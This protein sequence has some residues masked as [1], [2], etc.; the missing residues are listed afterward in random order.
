[1]S[2]TAM[3]Q[4]FQR[5]G[6]DSLTTPRRARAALDGAVLRVYAPPWLAVYQYCGT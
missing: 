5:T 2:N 1:M 3:E 6:S 4:L